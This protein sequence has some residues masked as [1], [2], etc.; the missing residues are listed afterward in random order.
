MAQ[1]QTVLAAGALTWRRH[2]GHTELL[3]IHRPK[4]DDW[5]FPKGKVDRGEHLTRAAVRETDEETGVR[6][7]LGAPL[8]AHEYPIRDSEAMKRVHYWVAQPIGEHDVGGYVPN[9]EVDAVRWVRLRDVAPLLT[10]DRDRAVLEAFRVLKRRDWHRARSLLV[11]RHADARSRSRWSGP[12]SERTLTR[13]G[14]RQAVRVRQVLAAYGVR[15]IVSSDAKR[16]LATVLPYADAI[17]ADV[18]LD[19]R[20]SEDRA[21]PKRARHAT[22]D[23]L[24]TRPPVVAVSHRPVLPY[25]TDALG[26]DD[27]DPLAPAELLVVHH[28]RGDI[29][30]TER[31]TP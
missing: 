21:K 20:L 26:L 3:M 19:P 11:L 22:Y 8:V 24:D 9:H 27:V 4:Y 18:V 5:T 10:Y 12:D 13:A 16:C 14:E 17:D 7:R 2:D 28:H 6:I 31:H 15:R 1:R 29:V 30:A 25:V 23:L